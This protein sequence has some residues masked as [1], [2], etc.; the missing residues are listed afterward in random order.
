MVCQSDLATGSTRCSTSA[1][2][3][4]AWSH[5]FAPL[6]GKRSTAGLRVFF[7]EHFGSLRH[8]FERMDFHHDGRLSCL[9]FQEVLCGQE[10]YCSMQ[11]AR[12]IFCWLAR[13]TAGWLTWEDFRSRLCEDTQLCWDGYSGISCE[14]PAS[15]SAQRPSPERPF[16]G[17]P[18]STQEPCTWQDGAKKEI[19]TE[20]NEAEMLMRSFLSQCMQTDSLQHPSQPTPPS[21][22]APSPMSDAVETE[23]VFTRRRPDFPRAVARSKVY[24]LPEAALVPLPSGQLSAACGSMQ[25]STHKPPDTRVSGNAK[26]A[27]VDTLVVRPESKCTM[28][29]HFSAPNQRSVLE[30]LDDGLRAWR[31]EVDAVRTLAGGVLHDSSCNSGIPAGFDVSTRSRVSAVN[32]SMNCCQSALVPTYTATSSTSLPGGLPWILSLPLHMQGRL[33]GCVDPLE[34]LDVLDEALGGLHCSWP[35]SC[36]VTPSADESSVLAASM[37][38]LHSVRSRASELEQVVI[39]QQHFH[40]ERTAELEHKQKRKKRTGLR[41]F[42]SRLAPPRPPHSQEIP[43]STVQQV[44]SRFMPANASAQS[45]C[46]PNIGVMETPQYPPEMQCEELSG[47][48]SSPTPMVQSTAFPTNAGPITLQQRP[49]YP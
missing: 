27:E 30:Q 6:P 8:A 13:G 20:V 48:V 2:V 24:S 43:P 10:R 35:S 4:P 28:L 26:T 44:C 31:A 7:I 29:P 45:V 39:D 22:S 9:E 33:A 3:G 15:A 49:A 23:D 32:A 1:G 37:E 14:S 19:E 17:G 25:R 5:F 36:S 40:E 34:A 41:Q 18:E 12:E 11:E 42:I 46:K 47:C 16:S 21:P 38:L